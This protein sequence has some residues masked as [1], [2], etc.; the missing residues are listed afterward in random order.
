MD[1]VGQII[2]ILL[3][4]GAFAFFIKEIR[5]RYQL[6]KLGKRGVVRWDN[7]VGRL[8]YVVGKVGSQ[9][10]SIKDRPVTGI[11]HAFIFY[12]F[13]FFAV[14]T[15]N[16]VAGAFVHG[17]SLFG[18][19]I[20]NDLWFLGVDIIAI[21][22]MVGAIFMFVRRFI[23]KPEPISKPWPLSKSPQSAI[24]LSFIFGLMV[25][26]LFNMGAEM[27]LNGESFSAWMPFSTAAS[28]MLA[29]LSESALKVW[30]GIFW[31]AHILMVLGFLVFIPHSKHLHL[32]A[33]PI[34]MFFHPK[35][36]TGTLQKIDFE[37]TEEFG[38]TNVSDFGWKN[39]MDFFS[40]VDCGRCQDV[41]PAYNSDKPL[42]P[43]VVMMKLRKHILNEAPN[44]LNGKEVGEPVMDGWQTPDEIWACTTCG[45]C[46]EACPV[47]NEHIPTIID[48][49]R[50]Q[51]MMDNKFPQELEPAF[52]GIENNSNPWN[53]GSSDR[54]AWTEGLDVPLMSEKGEAEYL[55]FVGCSG[56]FD[57]KGK[58]ISRSL[59]KILNKAGV[60][61]AILGTEE[62][63]C[64]DPARRAGNEYLFQMN[65]EENVTTFK[66]YKFSKVLTACPHGFQMIKN[67]YP[68]FEGDFEVVHHTELLAELIE[69]GKIN[70]SSNGDEKIT[71]HDSCYLG[72]YNNI[73]DAPR[74]V[75]KSI[76]NGNLVEMSRTKNKSFCCGA[77]GGRM[78]M[79]ESIGTR[80]NHLRVADVEECGASL[81]ASACPFCLTMLDDGIKEKGIKEKIVAKDVAQLVADR[82]L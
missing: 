53:I 25:T 7:P 66:Q 73:Y 67:E 54:A 39:I 52:R 38:V 36:A 42:S 47:N 80:I 13:V 20:F 62:K 69:Q 17:F 65:A 78:F 55:W 12:G 40:C 21:F 35:E 34:N 29:G 27:H 71:Y 4:L 63:C 57:D 9:L 2:L 24:V 31:R 76:S 72:R 30:N 45:A 77:G 60:D 32:V 37:E 1:L 26:Y 8:V 58:D 28:H 68:Q 75:L 19:N 3:I 49:R 6:V 59:A 14:A 11:M 44:L 79:E 41:C 56:S 18:K 5:L 15:V 23:I 82:L 70:L 74:N 61:Y 10:C 22:C 81:V 50:S 64:G 16:A 43:K 33:G 46:M 48:L 51:M